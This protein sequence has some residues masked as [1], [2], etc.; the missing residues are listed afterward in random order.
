MKHYLALATSLAWCS[1]SCAPHELVNPD[2]GRRARAVGR[3]EQCAETSRVAGEM[4]QMKPFRHYFRVRSDAV[5][6]LELSEYLPTSFEAT[7]GAEATLT[8]SLDE[9]GRPKRVSSLRTTTTSFTERT[10]C[11]S[12]WFDFSVPADMASRLLLPALVQSSSSHANILASVLEAAQRPAAAVGPVPASIEPARLLPPTDYAVGI[13]CMLDSH[14]GTT[15]ARARLEFSMRQALF[16]TSRANA[17]IPPY[18]LLG[19]LSA[20][21]KRFAPGLTRGARFLLTLEVSSADNSHRQASFLAAG[22]AIVD[23]DRGAIS[24]AYLVDADGQTPRSTPAS[25]QLGDSAAPTLFVDGAWL[26]ALAP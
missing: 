12:R 2:G 23:R 16:G 1:A 6:V 20:V 10:P 11:H 8:F 17:R 4:A 22:D 3:V 21:D 13:V 14:A 15:D 9:A 26:P 24:S 19:T 5:G 7:Y 18:T 25:I